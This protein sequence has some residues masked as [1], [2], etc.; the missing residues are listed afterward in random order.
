MTDVMIL[1]ASGVAGLVV[2]RV[3][4]S[5]YLESGGHALDAFDPAE[6]LYG[7]HA[8]C[9]VGAVDADGQEWFVVQNSW[10]T[11]WGDNGRALVSEAYLAATLDEVATVAPLST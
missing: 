4:E 7:R 2:I 3:Y 1:L 8:L 9:V 10:G 5:F 6:P 11:A